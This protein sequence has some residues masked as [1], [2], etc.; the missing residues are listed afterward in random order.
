MGT[1]SILILY[2]GTSNLG[3]AF[4]ASLYRNSF[5]STDRYRVW[6]S[7]LSASWVAWSW[8]LVQEHA[9]K[10]RHA[11]RGTMVLKSVNISF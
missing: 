10:K 11:E 8:Q 5:V 4:K 3:I 9:N 6:Q 2:E 7:A 1:F